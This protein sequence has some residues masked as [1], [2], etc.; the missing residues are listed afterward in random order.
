MYSNWSR[1]LIRYELRISRKLELARGKILSWRG[2]HIGKRFGLGKGTTLIYPTFL[3]IGDDVSLGE[4]SYLHC[5]AQKGVKIGK[6][7]S[8]DRNLWLHCGGT[9][10]NYDHGYFELGSYSYIGCNAVMGAGGGIRIGNHVLIG[11][12]VNIH[13]ENHQFN[14]QNLR[15][16][17]QG[18][19]YQGVVIEDDVWVGSKATILDGVTIG[20]GAVIGAGSI[21][22]RSIPP[23]SIAVGSPA[24][25]IGT[26]GEKKQ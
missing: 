9:S 15:I 16:N 8:I 17:Q 11:Q 3:T 18:V 2:A 5:L 21:V 25:V 20:Q 13:A 10:A 24:R 19:S 22:T 6:F 23:Y 12:C 4:Y 1:K 7:S 26:R 14:D